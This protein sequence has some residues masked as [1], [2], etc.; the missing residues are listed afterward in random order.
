[1]H[2]SIHKRI[3]NKG[4]S[5]GAGWGGIEAEWGCGGQNAGLTWG[6]RRGGAEGGHSEDDGEG[7]CGDLHGTPRQRLWER[8]VLSQ[9]PL[10]GCFAA[11]ADLL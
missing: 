5:R 10:Q 3:E 6:G 2:N 1:M 9:D 4:R 7:S 11:Q 8:H